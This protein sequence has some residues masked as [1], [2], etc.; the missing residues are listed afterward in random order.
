[1]PWEYLPPNAAAA[2]PIAANAEA[3]TIYWWMSVGFC[4]SLRS[5]A[6]KYTTRVSSF[7]YSVRPGSER[8]SWPCLKTP[9]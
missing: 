1:M 4:P 2:Q 5:Q 8:M 9:R 7:R 3:N 6:G